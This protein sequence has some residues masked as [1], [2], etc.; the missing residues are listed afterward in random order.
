MRNSRRCGGRAPSERPGESSACGRAN[1]RF[2]QLPDRALAPMS[3]TTR[4]GSSAGWSGFEEARPSFLCR[5][6]KLGH[7]RADRLDF[8][9]VML[10]CKCR[11]RDGISNGAA[12]IANRRRDTG[13]TADVMALV[14]RPTP[15]ACQL[16]VAP[17]DFRPR[18][19]LPAQPGH[20]RCA[21]SRESPCRAAM[22]RP[23]APMCIGSRWPTER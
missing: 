17:E 22:H 16:D 7:V 15:F 14:D 4:H 3:V 1:K 21:S 11:S 23:I 9:V 19:R 8:G 10:S 12:A 2:G 6:R 13:E 20:Q 18:C 5:R